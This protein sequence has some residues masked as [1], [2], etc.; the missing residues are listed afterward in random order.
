PLDAT[1]LG[2]MTLQR[3]STTAGRDTFVYSDGIS[4]IPNNSA[5]V[6]IGRS[7]SLTAE[8]EIPAN[9]DGMINTNGGRFG[10]YGFYLLKG[11]PVFP[12]NL[13]DLESVRWGG[14]RVPSAAQEH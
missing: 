9:C 8:V 4:G 13:L 14:P 3:P 6:F 12:W 11:K 1:K 10:G 2:R 7:Y 5:P